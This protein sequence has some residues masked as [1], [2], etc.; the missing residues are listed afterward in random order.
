[1][2]WEFHLLL[3]KLIP[4]LIIILPLIFL[5]TLFPISTRNYLPAATQ[6]LSLTPGKNCWLVLSALHLSALYQNQTAP[7]DVESYKTYPSQEIISIFPQLMIK[8]ISKTSD[9]TVVL[10]MMLGKLSSTLPPNAEAATLDIDAVFRCCPIA[11]SQQQSCII[12]WSNLFYINYNAPFSAA[13]SS[14]IFGRVADAMT[15]ILNSKGF[16][17][18]KNWVDDFV[19]FRFPISPVDNPAIFFYSLA[20]IHD[21]AIHLG[22]PWKSLKTILLLSLSTWVLLGVYLLR[23]SKFPFPKRLIIFQ[24]LNLGLLVR[25]LLGKRQN[26]YLALLFTVPWPFL[27]VV[28]IFLHFSLCSFI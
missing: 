25:S 17:P 26:Q 23:Q 21:L 1:M 19:F 9:A 2:T 28:L 11:P 8:L 5:F 10:L 4:L 22:Q 13:S 24:S 3:L 18:V 20:D 15:T 6:D 7:L 14:S 27:A 12:H 16:S